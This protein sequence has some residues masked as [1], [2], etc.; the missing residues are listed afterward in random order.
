MIYPPFATCYACGD[1]AVAFFLI[2]VEVV[3]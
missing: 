3:H 2:D 1:L